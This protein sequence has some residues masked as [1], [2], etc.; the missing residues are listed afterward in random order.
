MRTWQHNEFSAE[1]ET[2]KIGTIGMF[3][4]LDGKKEHDI[5]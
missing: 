4:P 2:C 5:N 1:N 3:S